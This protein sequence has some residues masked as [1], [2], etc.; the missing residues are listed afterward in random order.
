MLNLK[1]AKAFRLLSE[2]K[3]NVIFKKNSDIVRISWKA[4]DI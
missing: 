3:F 1:D 2:K 4:I